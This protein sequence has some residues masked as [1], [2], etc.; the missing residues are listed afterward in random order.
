MNFRTKI[1]LHFLGHLH[2]WGNLHFWGHLHFLGSSSFLGL[3]SFFRSEC[4]I[5]QFTLVL[6]VLFSCCSS[7]VG[8]IDLVHLNDLI[9]NEKNQGD[10]IHIQTEILAYYW[11]QL[12]AA[13][14]KMKKKN[15][16]TLFS[17]TLKVQGNKAVSVCL[18]PKIE[19]RRNH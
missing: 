15:K 19:Q 7:Y 17:S 1:C 10:N 2:L 4:G 9:N 13:M 14:V 16:S 12:C 11:P 3:S 18:S 8:F 6:F 5:V